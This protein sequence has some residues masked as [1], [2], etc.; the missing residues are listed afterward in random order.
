MSSSPRSIPIVRRVPVALRFPLGFAAISLVLMMLVTGPL[1]GIVRPFVCEQ[2]ALHSHLVLQALGES[3]RLSGSVVSAPDR[4]HAYQV[5][6]A[7][8]AI[9]STVLLVSAILAF[10]ASWRRKIAGVL[11]G[12]A[13][14]YVANLGRLVMLFYCYLY[15]RSIYDRLHLTVW[16]ALFV[17]LAVV[18]FFVWATMS[19]RVANDHA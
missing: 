11:L 13:I 3:T 18:L 19:T 2:V 9:P 4:G 17:V 5:V 12:A 10:P 15:Q 14:L 7:C 8:T 6:Y 1:E 16:Q